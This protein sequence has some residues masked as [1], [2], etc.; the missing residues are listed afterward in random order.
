MKYYSKKK[1]LDILQIFR[2]IA[3]LMVV[4]HHTIGSISFYHKAQYPFFTYLG[5]I[6]K[7]GV[8]FFFV[9][10]G[11]IISYSVFYS[12]NEPKAFNTYLKNRLLRIYIPYLPIGIL[13]LVLYTFLPNLSHSERTISTITSLTLLPN[14]NPA[15]SVAWSLTYELLFYFLFSISFFSRKMWNNF[16]FV[17]LFLLV[18]FNYSSLEVLPFLKTPFFQVLF[19]PYNFEFLLGYFLSLLII[20]NKKINLYLSILILIV[21]LGGFLSSL[22]INYHLFAFSTNLFFAL[23]VFF[24]LYV[25]I[26]KFDTSFKKNALFMLIGNATYSIYLIHNPLQMIVIRLY[27]KISS[28]TS[29]ILALL[30]C[31]VLSIVF[32]YLY[33]L[34]FEKYPIRKIKSLVTE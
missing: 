28:S 27:P 17:W 2:G 12:Y 22:F 21:T 32:G 15:L 1:Y 26:N 33:F 5:I 19:S 25:A 9:L 18:V 20:H 14:G 31:I 30:L 23:F 10:S 4:C 13:M 6:G 7:Y 11:F 16:V 29:L 24:L 3:A 34:L 8:D